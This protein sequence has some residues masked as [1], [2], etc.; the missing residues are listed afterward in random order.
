M[1]VIKLGQKTYMN[2]T[3]KHP[4]EK[5]WSVIKLSGYYQR[6]QH[7][8]MLFFS[9][10]GNVS[11]YYFQCWVLENILHSDMGKE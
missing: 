10:L 7:S 11:F 5:Q 6:E 1:I 3:N 4:I 8:L 9:A 2:N